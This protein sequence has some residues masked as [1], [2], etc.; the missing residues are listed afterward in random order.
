MALLVVSVVYR[1][2]RLGQYGHRR[3]TVDFDQSLQAWLVGG[4]SLGL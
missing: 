4:T 3:G 1:F 2:G